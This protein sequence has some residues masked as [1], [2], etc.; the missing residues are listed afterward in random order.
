MTQG[1][2]FLLLITVEVKIIRTKKVK[3]AGMNLDHTST[4][5]RTGNLKKRNQPHQGTMLKMVP[6]INQIKIF[7]RIKPIP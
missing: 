7:K 6:A 1:M 2:S 3:R 4:I 5:V